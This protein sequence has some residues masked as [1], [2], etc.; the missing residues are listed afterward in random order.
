MRGIGWSL[1]VG[2]VIGLGCHG[3]SSVVLDVLSLDSRDDAQGLS[4]SLEGGAFEDINS[5]PAFC[6]QNDDCPTGYW[7]SES[8]CIECT[9]YKGADKCRSGLCNWQGRCVPVKCD[10]QSDCE[11]YYCF[12]GFCVECLSVEDCPG[13][14]VCDETN[15]CR[16]MKPCYNDDDECPA[17]YHCFD[18][19]CLEKQ[20]DSH[21]DCLPSQY[22][23]SEIGFWSMCLPDV[24]ES[25]STVCYDARTI[26]Y[27][28]PDGQGY[29]FLYCKGDS[30]CQ[31][32]RCRGQDGTKPSCSP[33]C[34]NRQCGFDGCGRL[35][36]FCG[37]GESCD[38]GRC[39]STDRACYVRQSPGCDGCPCEA[40]VCK[41]MPECCTK[42]WNGYCVAKC[43]E[44]DP[45]LTCPN[46]GGFPRGCEIRECGLD[47][48]GAFC[49]PCAGGGYCLKG[50]CHPGIPPDLGKPCQF[51]AE[52][53]SGYCEP[54]G[55]GQSRVCT[56]ACGDSNA[57]ASGWT[58]VNGLCRTKPSCVGS[59]STTPYY[60]CGFDECGHPCPSCPSGKVCSN[61]GS[62]VIP[63]MGC[64]ATEGVPTCG[65]CECQTCVCN[66][67]P[68]CC[69]HEWSSACAL[70]C[71]TGCD[72]YDIMIQ[73]CHEPGFVCANLGYECG[74]AVDFAGFILD[75]GSC[76]MG[77]ECQ[78]HRCRCIP[79]CEG[80]VCGPDGCGG[81]CGDVEDT[82]N[83][84]L[85]PAQH[86][87][88]EDGQWKYVPLACRGFGGPDCEPGP[89]GCMDLNC[90]CDG[91]PL[92][93]EYGL[94]DETCVEFAMAECGLDC[95]PKPWP[96]S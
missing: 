43:V 91:M 82:G 86:V 51:S 77:Y 85:P 40:V 26:G 5:P 92:C 88:C 46:C 35:C 25:G 69:L 29:S 34:E 10:S 63:G 90:I 94:W 8:R 24:C 12:E 53:L 96:G 57:C 17:G 78:E 66:I 11:P 83:P 18:G 21:D 45:N 50:R 42:E 70:L 2:V 4:E 39:E 52:C 62:C 68:E 59:C 55:P 79:R 32:G 71:L 76:S 49:G 33:S 61:T 84:P 41:N 14:A 67:L 60:Q 72:P 56:V 6:A 89:P 23:S 27:C 28:L 7:C 3:N 19:L 16:V 1:V 75:C 38:D 95:T 9:T 48:C 13:N 36:G 64:T 15:R 20:C 22:C 37:E 44:V 65:G 81:Y 93:C 30:T 54:A 58:C 74:Y 47:P 31:D 80:R 87:F 73:K